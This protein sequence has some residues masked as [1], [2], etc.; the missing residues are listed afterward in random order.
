MFARF[1]RSWELIKA[2][3]AV[4]RQDKELLLFPFFAAIATLIV[5]ASFI[6][7]LIPDRLVEHAAYEPAAAH[8]H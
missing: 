2:S 8:R 4:L 7:P 6:V 5:A 3:G 1:S